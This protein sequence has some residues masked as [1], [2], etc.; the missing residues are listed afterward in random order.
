MMK[1]K[2]RTTRKVSGLE[3]LFKT[4]T[5]TI[6]LRQTHDKDLRD[7]TAKARAVPLIDSTATDNTITGGARKKKLK[8]KK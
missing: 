8:A 3:N 7:R 4:L 6:Q 1:R 5:S 2:K